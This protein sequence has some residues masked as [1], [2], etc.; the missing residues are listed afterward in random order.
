[1]WSL[2]CSIS[3]RYQKCE[4][5]H[6]KYA[7]TTEVNLYSME[8][9][10]ETHRKSQWLVCIYHMI[11]S[12]IWLTH[13]TTRLLRSFKELSE[14]TSLFGAQ[15][16]PWSLLNY[17][18]D[19]SKLRQFFIE[20]SPVSAENRRNFDPKITKMVIY[21]C[22]SVFLLLISFRWRKLLNSKS[23]WFSWWTELYSVKIL[24]QFWSV[25][26]T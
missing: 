9:F 3:V 23:R 17:T 2:F 16:G 6:Q 22:F 12:N 10:L 7:F 1:M 4:N 8:K 5:Y 13:F 20:F 14:N 25:Y 11:N 24:T 26:C 21:W 15:Y 18:V 19:T